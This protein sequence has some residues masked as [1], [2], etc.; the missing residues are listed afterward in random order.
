MTGKVQETR[1]A[2]NGR[3]ATSYSGTPV[4]GSYRASEVTQAVEGTHSE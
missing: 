2:D 3:S 4:E 1:R